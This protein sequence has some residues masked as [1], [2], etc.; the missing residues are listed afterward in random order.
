MLSGEPAG[1]DHLCR[2]CAFLL[3]KQNA[4]GGWGEDFTSCYDKVRVRVR[5]NNPNP[6]PNPNLA[7]ASTAAIAARKPSFPRARPSAATRS[8]AAPIAAARTSI[9]AILAAALGA[10]WLGGG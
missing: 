6:N 4:N 3:S 9:A 7:M 8:C 2:A 1:S 5:A 10:T